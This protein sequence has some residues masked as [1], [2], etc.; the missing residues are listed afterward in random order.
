VIA[1]YDSTYQNLVLLREK[2]N[3]S[4][5]PILVDGFRVESHAIVETDSG[6]YVALD[7]DADSNAHLAWYDADQGELRYAMIAEDQAWQWEVV[8]GEGPKDRGTHATLALDEGGV[9]HLAY[10]DQ[11]AKALRY[12]T[13]G[14][15]DIWI[16]TEIPGC[17]G[18]LDCPEAGEEDYGEYA[19]IA[20]VAGSPRIVFYDRMRGDLKLASQGQGGGWIVTTLDGRDPETGI[21]T[22]DVGKF[23]KV[24]VDPKRRLAVAYFDSSGKSL[25][26]LF[27]GS[28]SLAPVVVDDGVVFDADTQAMRSHVV[29]QHVAID[30]D[31]QGRA[32]L[33]YLDATGLVLKRATLNGQQVVDVSELAEESAGIAIS[34]AFDDQGRVRGAYGAWISDEAPRTELRYF[35]L[36]SAL[37]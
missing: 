31:A 27:E 37:P 24:A 4:L 17:A 28:A 32:L 34:F 35:E 11:T 26:Y 7:V 12:A 10:R 13:K 25:R 21:D 36:E 14:A 8:D 3:K 1:S 6:R 30:F 9:V 5:E 15:G 18:E 22:G 2:A 19:S 29:G 23:A 16:T 20:L 33:V